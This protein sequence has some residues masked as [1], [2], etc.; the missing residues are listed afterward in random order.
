MLEDYVLP[1]AI[2]M[3][4]EKILFSTYFVLGAILVGVTLLPRLSLFAKLILFL[5]FA[6]AA[7][8]IYAT[9]SATVLDKKTTGLYSIYTAIEFAF[10]VYIYSK[11]KLNN[12][13][14]PIIYLSII[15][16]LVFSIINLKFIQGAETFNTYTFVLG[17][18]LVSIFSY[19]KIRNAISNDILN[20]TDILVWFSVA[21]I[22]FYLGALPVLLSAPIF[23]DRTLKDLGNSLFIIKDVS[24]S[25]WSAIIAI[26]FICQKKKSI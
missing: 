10:I 12:K 4:Y 3:W 13:H 25:F 1:N 16:V 15:T 18:F 22:I 26:G 14:K 6:N 9:Y 19:Q 11:T 2:K 23:E 20:A 7:V 24:Y 17:G 21:N 5:L 8:D